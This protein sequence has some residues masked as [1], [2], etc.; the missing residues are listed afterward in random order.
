[1]FANLYI[2]STYFGQLLVM[3]VFKFRCSARITCKVYMV[4]K[5]CMGHSSVF[6]KAVNTNQCMPMQSAIAKNADQFSAQNMQLT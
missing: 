5:V 6:Q 4:Y 3:T 1:M 2:D